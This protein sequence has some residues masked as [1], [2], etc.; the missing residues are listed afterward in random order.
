MSCLYI[1]DISP[2]SDV[3]FVNIYIIIICGI[4][5]KKKTSEYNKHKQTHRENKLAATGR[6][7]R[8]GNGKIEVGN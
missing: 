5:K 6:E 8:G 7:R 3:L 1:L 2:L 4:L